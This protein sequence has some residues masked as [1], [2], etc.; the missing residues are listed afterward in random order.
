[1]DFSR[2]V[3][4]E[5][6]N[7]LFQHSIQS[8]IIEGGAKTVQQF[9]DSNLWDEAFIF[10][11]TTTFKEGIAAPKF[12]GKLIEEQMILDDLLSIYNNHD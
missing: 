7:Y 12:S 5:I 3:P 2:N 11:G 9:I 4:K 8:I 1:L 10:K 6:C